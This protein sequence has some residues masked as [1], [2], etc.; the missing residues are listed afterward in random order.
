MSV[1][2]L[3][4]GAPFY[5]GFKQVTSAPDWDGVITTQGVLLGSGDGLEILPTGVPMTKLGF[6]EDNSLNSTGVQR[7]RQLRTIDCEGSIQVLCRYRGC[8]RL[9]FGWFGTDTMTGPTDTVVYT[10]KATINTINKGNIFNFAAYDNL[11]CRDFPVC[12]VE[13]LKMEFAENTLSV[14]EAGLVA[15]RELQDGSGLNTTSTI[16]SV[17]LPS[18][19][20][21]V[22]LSAAST[23]L[24]MK[25]VTGSETALGSNDILYP[26]KISLTFARKYKKRRSTRNNPYID[27][28]VAGAWFLIGGSF[29]LPI[30]DATAYW[31]DIVGASEKKMDITFTGGAIAGSASS[32]YT[33]LFEYPSMIIESGGLPN[34]NTPDLLE[35]TFPFTAHRADANPG[36]M[37]FQ[38]PQ[39][40]CKNLVSTSFLNGG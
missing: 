40:T 24:R 19:K 9:I 17:T 39:F 1:I 5:G 12:K 30:D 22:V 15:K 27:E 31:T 10:H 16:T 23:V 7:K 11:V 14:L 18:P 35:V 20:E 13:H 8:E 2:N 25:T 32:F 28:P 37:S 6:V 21:Y 36:G 38:L 26:S 34:I 29:T 4:V 33:W 3:A